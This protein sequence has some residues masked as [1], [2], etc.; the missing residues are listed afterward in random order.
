MPIELLIQQWNQSFFKEI[1]LIFVCKIAMSCLV[2]NLS[3]KHLFARLLIS[4]LWIVRNT[5]LVFRSNEHRNRNISNLFQINLHGTLIF[6]Q[7]VLLLFL[8]S[9]ITMCI[10]WIFLVRMPTH[11][12][13]S[14]L[15]FDQLR[16]ARLIIWWEN[17]EISRPRHRS[18]QWSSMTQS[19]KFIP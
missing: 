11:K 2:N 15:N 12:C 8:L 13:H 7:M 18:I 9:C 14:V 1:Q 5:Q 4:S 6:Y 3:A 19:G 17:A 16:T 10:G